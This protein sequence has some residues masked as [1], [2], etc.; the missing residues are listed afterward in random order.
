MFYM[1]NLPLWQR[2][3]R[4]VAGFVMLGCGLI[5]F[6]GLPI[7]FLMAGVGIITGLTGVVGFCPMCSIAVK[8]SK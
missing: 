6:S 4:A 1:K 2:A 7:G 8:K 3:T 5:G